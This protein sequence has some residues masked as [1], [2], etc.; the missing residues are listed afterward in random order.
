MLTR[1][2]LLH[3]IREGRIRPSFVDRSDRELLALAQRLITTVVELTGVERRAIEVALRANAN[4]HQKPKI[5]RGFA[6]LLVDRMDF[7][8]AGEESE[9]LRSTTFSEASQVLRALPAGATF[10]EYERA[11]AERIDL[12]VRERLFADLAEH[13]PLL[14]FKPIDAE[15]LLDRYNLALA[16]GL[17]LYTDQL[18]ISLDRPELLDVRRLL[19]WLKFCRLVAFLERTED[20]WTLAVEGPGAI[21]SMQKKYGLQLANF[22]GAVP[23]LPRWRLSA[24]V[25]LPRKA[26]CALELSDEDPL[27]SPFSGAPG[28]VPEEVQ[29]FVEGFADDA[30]TI[31]TTPE[32]RPV[33][34][35]DVAVPDFVLRHR[36][37]GETVAVELFHRWHRAVL[38]RRIESLASRPDPGLILG[39]DRALLDDELAQRIEASERMFTFN[40]FPSKRALEKV[41]KRS[42]HSS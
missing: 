42:F 5:A 34:V 7:G 37:S 32:I 4:A 2:H 23:L 8:E 19:R 24:T 41:L 11:L 16:Q 13:R 29:Q 31:D 40:A 1:E 35:R 21:L 17:L 38:D 12:S 36:Q 33:G 25:K 9:E 20:Q 27:V 6:K 26:A 22:F 18:T 10:A 28:H 39:V 15:G 3:R 30:W 14:S